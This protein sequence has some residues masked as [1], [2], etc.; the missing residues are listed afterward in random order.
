MISR[1]LHVGRSNVPSGRLARVLRLAA[2]DGTGA[3]TG[4]LV[5]S[6]G[7]LALTVA[8]ARVAG[9]A[10]FGGFVVLVAVDTTISSLAAARWCTPIASFASGRSG[11]HVRRLAAS[12][13]AG[14]SRWLLAAVAI[15]LPCVGLAGPLGLEPLAMLCFPAFL[16]MQ[17]RFLVSRTTR[18][19]MFDA[20]R[21]V[22]A[23][24]VIAGAPLVALAL[25]RPLGATLDPVS[26]VWLGLIVGNA[27]A[28]MMTGTGTHP[29]TIANGADSEFH[30]FG[31]RAAAGSGIYGIGAR[32]HPAVLA[33][34]ASAASVAAFG[35]AAALAGPMRLV[36]AA[37]AATLHPR[38]AARSNA[39]DRAGARRIERRAIGFT[40]AIGMIATIG[41][42]SIG[43][44]LVPLVFGAE[45]GAATALLAWSVVA[46]TCT[47]ITGVQTAGLQAGGD[48]DTPT[49][50]RLLASVI[51]LPLTIPAVVVAGATG[52]FLAL[53]VGEVVYGL[54]VDRR[55]S[56]G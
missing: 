47:A 38:M 3:M 51:G 28:L 24:L 33:G 35:A 53:I 43:P 29:R 22:P 52:A 27:I 7:R 32:L 12:A 15:L 20:W 45:Y 48:A 31:R 10:A 8:V 2:R 4:N 40:V 49:R 21:V 6:I 39:G 14:M 44:M 30:R 23:E 13:T 42:L 17:G 1:P 41:A 19:S 56:S 50:A 5:R 9:P 26:T 36:S 11:D 18:L 37:F 34:F 54:A 55:R 46:A 16:W 25:T